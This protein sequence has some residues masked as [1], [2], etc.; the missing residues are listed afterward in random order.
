MQHVVWETGLLVGYVF[1]EPS[2]VPR[3]SPLVSPPP[4]VPVI[5]GFIQVCFTD[6]G[7]W[8]SSGTEINRRWSH[9]HRL[10]HPV[11][12]GTVCGYLDF[13]VVFSALILV[14]NRLL[15]RM[16]RARFSVLLYCLLMEAPCRD[17]WVD[18]AAR[19]GRGQEGEWLMA[20]AIQACRSGSSLPGSRPCSLAYSCHST[21]RPRLSRRSLTRRVAAMGMSPS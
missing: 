5:T 3:P 7:W 21:F 13:F 17:G 10:S 8:G 14:F 1:V 18:V 16:A 12:A 4:H 6:S 11:E 9:D 2:L 20:V 15:R 19:T